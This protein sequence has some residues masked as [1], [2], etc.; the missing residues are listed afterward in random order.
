MVALRLLRLTA[1]RQLHPFWP[2]CQLDTHWIPHQRWDH[3]RQ[4]GGGV[5]LQYSA[6]GD[7]LFYYGWSGWTIFE[8]GSSTAWQAQKTSYCN[9]FIYILCLY[10]LLSVSDLW[11][12]TRINLTE[13]LVSK[14]GN[15]YCTTLTDHFSKWAEAC[16]YVPLQ[17]RPCMKLPSCTAWSLDMGDHKRSSQIKVSNSLLIPFKNS[18]GSDTWSKELIILNRMDWMNDLIKHWNI[19]FNSLSM[20]TKMT[21]MSF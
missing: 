10:T 2:T 19:S 5:W 15:W 6:L 21:G 20:V 13:Q 3:P 9:F 11:N 17:R 14:N 18:L 4:G 8:K 12:K 1:Y 7:Q 16:Q